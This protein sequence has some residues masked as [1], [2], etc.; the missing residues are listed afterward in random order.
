M[1]R[2]KRAIPSQ[3]IVMLN[4]GQAILS[5]RDFKTFSEEA[6]Q[7]NI[8]AFRCIDFIANSVATLP[9]CLYQKTK[10]SAD[11]LVENH[12][13]ID[14]LNHPNPM[15]SK[16]EFFKQT[17]GYFLISGND[18]IQAIGPSEN[19]P[20]QELWNL[21]PQF[22][23]V[24]P[25]QRMIPSAYK[26][27]KNG[28]DVLFQ[29][30]QVDGSSSIRHLKTFH[31]TNWW[32]GLSPIEAASF[33]VDQHNETGKWNLSLLQNSARP[34]GALV[35]NSTAYNTEGVLTEEQKAF[36]RL[37][38]QE[39]YSGA[40]NSG[41]PIL[42]EGGM[43]WKEMGFSPQDMNW[44]EG[45][46]T[47]ARDIALAFGVPSQLINVPGESTYANYEQANLAFFLHT[48]IPLGEFICDHLNS[49]LLPSFMPKG[50]EYD[51]YFK[52]DKSQISAL[53]ILRKEKWSQA[54]QAT[55]LTINEKRELLGYGKYQGSEEPA[56]MI[57]APPGATPIDSIAENQGDSEDGTDTTDYTG[58]S[59]GDSEDGQEDQSENGESDETDSGKRVIAYCD[60]K[61]FNVKNA[62]QRRKY[63][64]S[65]TKKRNNLAKKFKS[66]L[67]KVWKKERDMLKERFKTTH[68][69]QEI[70]LDIDFVLHRTKPEFEKVFKKNIKEI[71]NTFGKDVLKLGKEWSPDFEF[72]SA[73]SK[74]DQYV[75]SY[76]NKYTGE[77]ITGI[78]GNTQ[79]RLLKELR[80][81]FVESLQEGQTPDQMV[82][83][84]TEMYSKFTENRAN[85]IV[86]TETGMAQNEAQREAAGLLDIT[87]DEGKK[88]PVKK[89]WLSEQIERT[90]QFPRDTTNHWDMNDISILLDDKFEV[91]SENGYDLM[92]GPGDRNAPPEQ[93]INCHCVQ[94]FSTEE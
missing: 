26:M 43:D 30:D 47:S 61:K 82:D 54:Q 11:N 90:R 92:D 75:E 1:F 9:I 70:H 50:K 10:N 34:S 60:T 53:E 7:K 65:I 81:M 41:K 21:S 37:Q 28:Q 59:S 76:V 13:V 56:D 49:W 84:I 71:M 8:I 80:E 78:Y 25:G 64:Y 24:I 12:P 93:I 77:K 63:L 14:L 16:I 72:K 2:R 20:P 85:V 15:Q 31:P 19:Q 5:P 52:I 29:V 83:A 40:N 27:S 88:I 33:S 4:P 79:K 68:D 17:L 38:I 67:V 69:I 48:V 51:L 58:D 86:V 55:Y 73:D 89:T 62:N 44:I 36:L 91:P 35:V 87:D 22:M 39:Q 6:Y 45:K 42:L 18:Y 23:K 57:F 94:I 32:Y 66:E 3:S 46:N 74:F